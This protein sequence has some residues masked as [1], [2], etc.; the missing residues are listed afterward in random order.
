MIAGTPPI[1][2]QTQAREVA[3]FRLDLLDDLAARLQDSRLRDLARFPGSG[4]GVTIEELRGNRD[5]L[6]RAIQTA[7][8]KYLAI[9]GA[10]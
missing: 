10:K 9:L 8:A 7:R 1:S 3:R 4:D 6:F 2:A 5:S